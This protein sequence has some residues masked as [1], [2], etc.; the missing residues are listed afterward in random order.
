MRQLTLAVRELHHANI[1]HMNLHP[2]NIYIGRN[3]NLKITDFAHSKDTRELGPVKFNI[4][5]MKSTDY[6]A[7]EMLKQYKPTPSADIYSLGLIFAFI[8]YGKI[9]NL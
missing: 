9:D 5:T 8:K 1:V 2:A 6:M 3:N 4:S 7:P